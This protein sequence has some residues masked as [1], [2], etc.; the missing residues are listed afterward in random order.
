MLKLPS[1]HPTSIKP[2]FHLNKNRSFLLCTI[3][4]YSQLSRSQPH[5]SSLSRSLWSRHSLEYNQK[6][7]SLLHVGDHNCKAPEVIQSIYCWQWGEGYYFSCNHQGNKM[8]INEWI[9]PNDRSDSEQSFDWLVQCQ[10]FVL[11]QWPSQMQDGGGA[12]WMVRGHQWSEIDAAE[13]ECMCWRWPCKK[14]CRNKRDY[15]AE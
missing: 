3:L 11:H 14:D 1:S 10:S 9:G 12:F 15:R 8:N 4:P 6:E 5:L 13:K 7:H 2:H